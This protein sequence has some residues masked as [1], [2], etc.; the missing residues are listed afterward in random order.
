MY[1]SL[2]HARPFIGVVLAIAIASLGSAPQGSAFVAPKKKIDIVLQVANFFAPIIVQYIIQNKPTSNGLYAPIFHLLAHNARSQWSNIESIVQ[3]AQRCIQKERTRANAAGAACIRTAEEDIVKQ[4]KSIS[5]HILKK[6]C[7]YNVSLFTE[8]FPELC[9]KQK[10]ISQFGKGGVRASGSPEHSARREWITNQI[11]TGQRCVQELLK[12]A[13][14]AI[15]DATALS[16]V[17]SWLSRTEAQFV[18]EQQ[19]FENIARTPERIQ[20]NKLRKQSART[21]AL[22]AT[23]CHLLYDAKVQNGEKTKLNHYFSNATKEITDYNLEVSATVDALLNKL[24]NK[25]DA[26]A[27][28]CKNEAMKIKNALRE[29]HVELTIA[30]TYWLSARN[31]KDA[32]NQVLKLYTHVQRLSDHHAQRVTELF[33]ECLNIRIT[34]T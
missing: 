10:T 27:Q 11:A 33:K 7:P 21:A 30:K 29:Q 18:K 24:R 3:T 25:S 26:H 14:Q 5:A 13:P 2:R 9:K 12:M 23:V 22:V 20:L 17:F 34:D 1:T 4:L 28:Y 8:L 31:R 19:Q 16:T 32:I 15:G 6:I